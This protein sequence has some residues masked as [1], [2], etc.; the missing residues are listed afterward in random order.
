MPEGLP[1]EPSTSQNAGN[2]NGNLNFPTKNTVQTGI[3]RYFE[4]SKRK[5][6]PTST[7][8]VPASKQ[9]RTQTET[10]SNR[11]A[12]LATEENEET[13]ALP[14]REQK[15]PPV[16]V[17]E[18]CNNLLVNQISTLIG[19]NNFH[20]I[21][22]RSG[23]I[24]ETKV[25]VYTE[26]S[27]R[28]IINFFDENKKSYYTYQLKSAKGLS[29][30]LKGIESSVPTTEIKE[31]LESVGYEV[32]SIQ[33]VVNK[34]K[35]PQPLFRV[36][37]RFDK[38]TVNKN[39]SH[40]IYSLR[41]LLHRRITVEQPHKRRSP[42]QCQNCQEFGHTRTYCKLPAVCVICGNL[43]KTVECKNPKDDPSL[44][45][46]SN[47]GQNHTANYRGCKVFIEMKKRPQT[48]NRPA[49][50]NEER[51]FVQN[52]AFLAP[53]VN[54]H[55]QKFPNMQTYSQVLRDFEPQPQSSL[56][57]SINNLVQSI[58]I[59]M[60]RMTSMMQEMMRNQSILIQALAK[61]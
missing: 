25:Q 6:S 46:C 32:K 42:V 56:E 16:Y 8:Q 3:D 9:S 53:K 5:R 27:Y 54:T 35:I 52:P 55:A 28:N 33:N 19:T 7:N 37:I 47:C 49:H 59:F 10:S 30:V 17:R 36:E 43:H 40:P 12:I 11:F 20:V 24:Q 45:K 57:G 4:I 61:K 13:P 29:V 38:H 26:K 31:A 14:T 44:K 1:L 21:S 60:D 18:Q 15:P 48:T 50:R 58:H 39:E 23:N 2:E 51:T 22:V 34:N 41:Y